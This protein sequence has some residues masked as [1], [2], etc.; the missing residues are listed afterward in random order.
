MQE[1]ITGEMV[2]YL[3]LPCKHTKAKKKERALE[4]GSPKK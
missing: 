2:I 4:L 3:R 1:M